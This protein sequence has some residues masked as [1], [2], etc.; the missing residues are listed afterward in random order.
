MSLVSVQ[1][2]STKRAAVVARAIDAVDR[3]H[4]RAAMTL[5][6][7]RNRIVASAERGLDHAAALID[8]ARTRLKAIDATSADLV[9]RAQGVVGAAI[10]RA[11]PPVAAA[12]A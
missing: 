3:A 4:A 11:R 10:E 7:A 1:D 2:L 12:S 9:N 8:S 5:H 6:E